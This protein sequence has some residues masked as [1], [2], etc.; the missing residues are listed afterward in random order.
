MS[1][2]GVE[3]RKMDKISSWQPTGSF[4]W[5]FPW[6]Q[7]KKRMT[8]SDVRCVGDSPESTCR[9]GT[10]GIRPSIP[11]RACLFRNASHGLRILLV[12]SRDRIF[13][14]I[15]IYS[16]TNIETNSVSHACTQKHPDSNYKKKKKNTFQ[17]QV[18]SKCLYRAK[19]RKTQP[20]IR[21]EKDYF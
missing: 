9:R 15:K 10:E 3:V 5:R 7:P 19:S 12:W 18:K 20:F 14:P 8:V 16:K 13:L 17:T 2:V 21:M 4:L 6:Q 1:A 11:R